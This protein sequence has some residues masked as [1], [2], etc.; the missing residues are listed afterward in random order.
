MLFIQYYPPRFGQAAIWKLGRVLKLSGV[1]V[2][3]GKHITKQMKRPWPDQSHV[4]PCIYPTLSDSQGLRLFSKKGRVHVSS[5]D[6][7]Q[8]KSIW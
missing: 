7:W 3:V 4:L 1:P 5:L 8:M 6:I 2:P